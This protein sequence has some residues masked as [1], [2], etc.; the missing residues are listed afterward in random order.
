MPCGVPPRAECGVAG[1]ALKVRCVV[2]RMRSAV[3]RIKARYK[4]ARSPILFLSETTKSGCGACMPLCVS[5]SSL[6]GQSR[7]AARTGSE[8]WGPSCPR[9]WLGPGLSRRRSWTLALPWAE[10]K[11]H[12][13][14][15]RPR[16]D[17]GHATLHSPGHSKTHGTQHE[18]AA[19]EGV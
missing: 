6:H 2:G 12:R 10:A 17:C 5:V 18:G 14:C 15:W 11:A 16:R 9:V 8:L 7:E 19:C 13:L 4:T 1:K 3:N